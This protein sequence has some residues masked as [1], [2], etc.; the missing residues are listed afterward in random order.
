MYDFILIKKNS[1]GYSGGVPP[2]PIPNTA[3]KSSSAYGT[4]FFLGEQVAAG[5]LY[6]FT[7][8]R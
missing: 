7:D 3:V 5:I 6:I 4:R 2:V 1:G 8:P